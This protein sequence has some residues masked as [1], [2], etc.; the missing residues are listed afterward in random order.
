LSVAIR[1]ISD[2]TSFMMPGR[3]RP[4]L[5]ERPLPAE[6]T[7]EKWGLKREEL[8]DFSARSHEKVGGAIAEGRFKREIVPITLPDGAVFD[9]DEGVRVPVNR[10]KMSAWG[11]PVEAQRW[12]RAGRSARSVRAL[13]P[14]LGLS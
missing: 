13:R 11:V 4:L 2:E 12:C 9:T 3:P 1:R 8:D 6:L 14:P 10:E 7:D 5:L